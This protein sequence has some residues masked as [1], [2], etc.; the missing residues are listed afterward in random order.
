VETSTTLRHLAAAHGHGHGHDDDYRHDHRHDLKA[1]SS[2]ESP[3]LS[4]SGLSGLPKKQKALDCLLQSLS[5]LQAVHGGGGKKTTAP[6][7]SSTLGLG[8]QQGA[9]AH[10]EVGHALLAVATLLRRESAS[11]PCAR[12]GNGTGTGTVGGGPGQDITGV[13]GGTNIHHNSSYD[14]TN[15][16]AAF[17]EEAARC[18]MQRALCC[19]SACYGDGHKLTKQ[20]RDLLK[21]MDRGR[22]V[23]SCSVQ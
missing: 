15:S 18:F 10:P 11:Q 2:S 22:G 4:G 5:I 19:Y 6:L 21:E 20:T 1:S 23:S 17:S 3:G 9:A 8:Q 16:T 12:N 13:D 7:P 14:T